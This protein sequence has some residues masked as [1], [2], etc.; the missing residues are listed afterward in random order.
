L[1]GIGA[2]IL[3]TAQGAYISNCAALHEQA[4]GLP[5]TSTLGYFNGLFFSLFQVNQLVGNLLAALLFKADVSQRTIFIIMTTICA[6]GCFTLLFLSNSAKALTSE[7]RANGVL[8]QQQQ[9]QPSSPQDLY[10]PNNGSNGVLPVSSE[11]YASA[12]D[13]LHVKPR[14]GGSEVFR[15]VVDSLKMLLEPRMMILAPIMVF[16]GWSQGYFF[17]DFPPLLEDKATKFFMLAVVGATNA[18]MSALMGRLS[19]R[20]G[21]VAVL[22]VGFVCAGSGILFLMHWHVDQDAVYVFFL[23]G[24]V[25]GVADAVFNTQIYALVGSWFEGRVEHAFAIFKFFQAGSTAV[26][27]LLSNKLGFFWKSVLCVSALASGF[28]MLFGFDLY[29]RFVRGRKGSVLDGGKQ[30][31]QQQ[32]GDDALKQPLARDSVN[33]DAIRDY[34]APPMM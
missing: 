17:G 34:E 23:V 22:L 8:A 24:I 21:R 9:Q 18:F 31:Q 27:F 32:E 6:F 7:Q 16:S 11:Q 14:G 3:W 30:Q 28:V 19:D 1:I 29:C 10:S 20:V 12:E 15:Q 5:A 25:F 13:V 33:I 2:S 4:H 26:A